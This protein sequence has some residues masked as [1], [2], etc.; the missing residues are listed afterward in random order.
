M[1]RSSGE[2]IRNNILG[3]ALKLEVKVILLEQLHPSC[4]SSGELGLSGKMAEC[5]MVGIDNKVG[6]IEIITPGLECMDHRKEFL[7]MS[8]VVPL[9][10]VH[11]AGGE[12]HWSRGSMGVCLEENS[13]NSE[14][15]CIG[16]DS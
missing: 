4:L 6:S 7:F 13:A 3:A 14:A 5:I 12:G 15:R 11:L 1:V 8:R 10:G 9:C 16:F 2:G